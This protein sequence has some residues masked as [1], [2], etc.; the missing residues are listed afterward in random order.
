M[1]RAAQTRYGVSGTVYEVRNDFFGETVS[2]AGLLTGGDIA[3]QLEGKP[4]GDRLLITRNML[5]RGE[6]VFLDDMTVSDL[7]RRLGT[8][9]RVVEQSGDDL[10][11]AMLGHAPREHSDGTVT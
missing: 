11:R 2:V 6:D 3:S 9:V 10:L 1:A 7:E 4:L 8:P 5:R